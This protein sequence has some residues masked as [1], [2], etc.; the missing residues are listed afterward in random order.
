VASFT[1]L[2]GKNTPQPQD[3]DKPFPLTYNALFRIFGAPKSEFLSLIPFEIIH[4]IRPGY[5]DLILGYFFLL[6]LT[7]I[8]LNVT[9]TGL[10]NRLSEIAIFFIAGLGCLIIEYE[11]FV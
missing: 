8:S 3:V 10:E 9:K 5:S 11:G 4:I 1:S 2:A 7:V 6:E